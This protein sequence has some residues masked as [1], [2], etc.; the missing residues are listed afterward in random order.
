MPAL[1]F[2]N[3]IAYTPQAFIDQSFD[4]DWLRAVQEVVAFWLGDAPALY[5]Q[6]SGSTG[7]PKTIGLAREVLQASAEATLS[8]LQLKPGPMLL[9]L[10]AQYIG[11]KMMI[12]RALVGQFPLYLYPPKSTLPE[13]A[14][15]FSLLAL[16]PFQAASSLAQL[17][18]AAVVILGGA[19]VSTDLEAQLQ[20]VPS[21]IYSS[22][23]MTETASH[24]ALRRIN[25][26]GRS[27][28][29]EALPGV[30]FSQNEE[31]CLVIDAPHLQVNGLAT[32]D[33]VAINNKTRFTWLGRI[34]HVINSGGVKLHPEAIE[35]TLAVEIKHP[36]FVTSVPDPLLGEKLVLLVEHAHPISIALGSLKGASRPK[37]IYFLPHF[38]YTKTG[39]INRSKTRALWLSQE[40][41]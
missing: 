5:T 32:N 27:D 24:V 36:F 9:F 39:K 13:L 31:Q 8:F 21:A 22:Y 20:A 7:T 35:R 29:F 18:K 11:G 12:I 10:P 4:E 34:D 1:F 26:A 23:G 37:N 19:T 6:T 25:G 17:H 2:Y 41:N 3:N 38:V 33:V 30:T 28:Y 14:N 16:T 15:D 40:N